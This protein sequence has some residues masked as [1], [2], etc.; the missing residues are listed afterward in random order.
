M[1][2]FSTPFRAALLWCLAL[3]MPGCIDP[4]MPEAISTTTNFL[5]VDGFINSDGITTINLSRTYDISSSATPPKVT[6][7]TVYI[8]EDGG[9]RYNLRESSPG[10]YTSPNLR[11]NAAKNHRLHILTSDSKDYASEYTAVK[12][13]PPID[14][15]TWRAVDTG[16]NIYV[17][18]HDD[19]NKTQYYRWEFEE[20]WE[21]AT[22]YSPFIEYRNGQ[23]QSITTPYPRLCWSNAK[24]ADIKISNTT[25]LTKDVISDFLLRS[26]P[27]TSE[28]FNRRY[29]ILVKQY[30]QTA[31]EYMY[32]DL[33]RKN[34]EQI[35]TLFDPL[36]AQLT[37]NIRCL[38]DQAELALGYVGVHSVQEKRIFI[39]RPELPSTWR[40]QNGY[41]S[42]VP[43]D[44]VFIAGPEIRL[45]PAQILQNAFSG[46]TYLPIAEV[47]NPI[48]GNLVGYT[49][50]SRDCIDC[51]TRGSAIKPSFWP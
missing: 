35:G 31:E 14:N 47:Y 1:R 49:A 33:L 30:A 2:L 29:S 39:A 6:R 5:V 13:T 11:L 42:C 24:S 45:P 9:V 8:E 18:T 20:T 21:I 7:A 22:P 37:G 36:P 38:N 41:E 28:L 27:T 12:T 34:T 3:L 16:L 46:P 43:P 51:R 4:Y 26:F 25:R 44:T 10:I 32:W 15:I 17:N 40:V 48:S 19:T 50:K 23:I